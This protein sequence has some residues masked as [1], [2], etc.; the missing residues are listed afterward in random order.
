[1]GPVS[2]KM[3]DKFKLVLRIETTV[4]NP[5]FFKHYREVVKRDGTTIRKYAR[6]KKNIYSLFDLQKILNSSNLRYIEFISSFDDK[7]TGLKA[8]NKITQKTIE[9]GCSYRGFNFFNSDDLDLV[10]TIVRGEYNISGFQNKDIRKQMNNKNSSQISRIIKRLRVH[11]VIKKV[12]NTY[13]YY[14]TSLGR[15]VIATALKL[16]EL[17][18]IPHLSKT[19][20]I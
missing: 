15:K 4:N 13:K 14:L 11:G 20:N 17:F 10:K 12:R 19:S 8:L 2:I 1:M 16:K 3:Y 9:K 6:M 7:S 5:T 18:I